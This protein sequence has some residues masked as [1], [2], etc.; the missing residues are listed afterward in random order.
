MN[1]KLTFKK[2]VADDLVFLYDNARYLNQ[3]IKFVTKL[4]IEQ[5]WIGSANV[6]HNL[7]CLNKIENHPLNLNINASI[8]NSISSLVDNMR[9]ATKHLNEFLKKIAVASILNDLNYPLNKDKYDSGEKEKNDYSDLIVGLD[10]IIPF[11]ATYHQKEEILD[12]ETVHLNYYIMY[13]IE[14]K[15]NFIIFDESFIGLNSNF[16]EYKKD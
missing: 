2:I 4:V 8:K 10:N 11:I 6:S 5:N 7:I 15:N 12:S 14:N 1:Y 3:H 9:E 13:G 16:F